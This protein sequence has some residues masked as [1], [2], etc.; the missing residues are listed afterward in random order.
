V[1]VRLAWALL[2]AV[3]VAAPAAAA[4]TIHWR[5]S[6][7]IGTPNHG[8]LVRGVQLPSEGLD[9]FTWDLVRE[10]F[11]NR[12]WRRWGT[13]RLLETLLTVLADYR[14]AHPEAPRVG[15]SDISRP[16]GGWFGREFGGLGHASHQNGLDVDVL[17]PRRDRSERVAHVPRQVDVRLSQDLLNRFVRAGAK[18]VFVG[19]DLPLRGPRRIVQKLVYHDD[20]MHVRLRPR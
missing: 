1:R 16:H 19:P 20:H 14:A 12:P 8:A 7:A 10:R 3:L 6:V 2:A 18:Y 5:R 13:D 4:D 17:Y 11:T 9:W 15:V